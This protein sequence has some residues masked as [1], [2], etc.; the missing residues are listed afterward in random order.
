VSWIVALLVASLSAQA[1]AAPH[2]PNP[3]MMSLAEALARAEKNL[4]AGDL[5][6][7]GVYAGRI[8]DQAKEIPDL[9]RSDADADRGFR[10]SASALG[11]V[12]DE[13]NR[14]AKSG[15]RARAAS[16]FEDL[17]NACVQCHVTY[18]SDDG[19]RGTFPA[20]WNTVAGEVSIATVDGSERKDRSNVVVFLEGVATPVDRAT[21]WRARQ[22]TQQEARFE[23][24]VLPIVRGEK[25]E[26]PNDD[27]IFHNVFSLSETQPFD[28]G[29]YGPGQSRSV[30]F[31]RTGL[32]RV[33]CNIHPQMLSTILVLENPFFATTDERGR[34]TIAGVP[35]GTYV[36]RAWQEFGGD[37]R[38]TVELA[39]GKLATV[40][41]RLAED[42]VTLEHRNKFGLPYREAYR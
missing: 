22:I 19:R 42:K 12:A 26:F 25:V 23:P 29:A 5:A 2:D 13:A 7:F 37:H 17:R 6:A 11:S 4:G 1:P 27:F 14:L 16:A 32:V 34:F 33:Y 30:E 20:R 8:R 31:P 36:L 3:L 39:G 35:D 40:R 24:R 21:P 28:L 41:F 9:R 15:D 18:R 38:E 10:A